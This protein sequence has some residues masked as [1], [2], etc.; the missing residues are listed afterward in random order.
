MRVMLVIDHPYGSQAWDNTPHQR[1]FTAAL[2]HAA[3]A[4]LD[5]AGHEV[6]LVDLHGDGFDPVMSAQDLRTWRAGE[7]S[8][9]PLTADYQR[10]LLL[11]DHLVLAFPIWWEAMPA[12]M[13][14]F[15]DKVVAK[16]VAYGQ[17]TRLRPM[18][19]LTKLGGV[20]LIT[21][22]STPTP[23]YR[24]M[25]GSAISK[26]LLRGT[27]RKIG[28]GNLTWL[29]HSGVERK[30]AEAR[31]QMLAATE[32]RFA[33]PLSAATRDDTSRADASRSPR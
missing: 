29:S 18:T 16:G 3:M 7:A 6:D 13:K 12:T 28:V 4:G 23:L 14:G 11:A 24:L 15:I 33:R 10:R 8:S 32:R 5:R 19:N 1:S 31:S 9:E 17:G 2:A 21:V 25:F 22:M 20:T 27:F 30:S 26:I